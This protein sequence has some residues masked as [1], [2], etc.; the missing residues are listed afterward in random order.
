VTNPHT[1]HA[2]A[3]RIQH[4]DRADTL[5]EA[6]SQVLE[7]IVLGHP[8]HKILERLCRIAEAQATR[9]VRC[10]IALVDADG[11]RLQTVAAP[12]I[13]EVYV[14]AHDGHPISRHVGTSCAAAASGEP[15]V[16]PDIT[17]D[18]GWEPLRPIAI[19]YGLRAAWSQPIKAASGQVLGTFGTYFLERRRPTAYE[20]RL[21][22]MLARTAALAIEH[23]RADDSMRASAERER[24]L[25]ELAAATQPLSEPSEIMAVTARMLAQHLD[26]DRCTYSEVDD[27]QSGRTVG[28]YARGVPSAI[29]RWTA[30]GFGPECVESLRAGR[31]FVVNDVGDAPE[32][33]VYR[34]AKVRA[35]MIAPLLKHGRLTAAIAVHQLRP[36]AW[37]ADEVELL[38]VVCA[39]CWETLERAKVTRSLL[40]S[41]ARHRRMVEASPECVMLVAADGTLL[42]MNA[43]GSRMLEVSDAAQVVGRSIYPSIAPEHR[44]RFREWNE[45]VCAGNQGTLEFE[46]IGAHGGRRHLE[47]TAVWLPAPGGDGRVQ[48][49][50][51][52]DVSARVAADQALHESRARLDYAV[53]LSGVG[54][55]Y[56]D[57]PLDE[58]LWDAR[59]K[60]LFFLPPDDAP[61]HVDEIFQ[62][63]HP[64]DREWVNETVHRA[65]AEHSSCDM[66]HRTL[67]PRSGAIKWVRALGGCRYGEDGTPTTF[68]GVIV[69]VTSQRLD[70]ERLARLLERERE[71]T[72]LL[73]QLADASLRIHGS[74][75]LEN[76][77]QA[78]TEQASQLIGAAHAATH[79]YEPPAE[80][81]RCVKTEPRRASQLSAPLIGRHGVSLGVV[82]LSDKLSGEFDEA[83]VAILAQLAHI[84]AVAIENARLYDQLREQDRRKD[85]FLA[86]LAH[87]LRNPL[88]PI[89][90]G[91]GVLKIAGD[92]EQ[93]ARAR[94]M[95]ERQLGHM[96]RMVDDLLEISR[97]T[98]G[99]LELKKERVDARA[100]VKQAL[101][102]TLPLVQARKHEFSL[103]M[104]DQ[105]LIVHADPTRLS[106]IIVNLVNNAA[107]YTPEGGRIALH[108]ESDASRLHIRVCDSGVGIAPEMLPKVFDMFTQVGGALERSQGGLGIGLTLVR[109]LVEMHGGTVA[110]S[111]DGPGRGSTFTVSLPLSVGQTVKGNAPYVEATRRGGDA[112]RILVVDDNVDGAECL[113]L[114]LE[115]RGHQTRVAYSGADALVAAR[116]FRPDVI[117]LDIG[118]PGLDGYQVAEKLRADPDLRNTML[119]A[120]TGWGSSSDR[121]RA[122]AAGFDQH[123]VKPLDTTKLSEILAK[124]EVHAGAT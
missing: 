81:A 106:Q 51:G 47:T 5:F 10:A 65:I 68:N 27:L 57:L 66:T 82:S 98:L 91:L 52:R 96:V 31:P 13:P 16:T 119:V 6:Q 92:S 70:Q 67:D 89:R 2:A 94:D 108:A 12:T 55:F 21:V 73:G 105:P 100:V 38:S 46:I 17:T 50:M 60:E 74:G 25:S 120:L 72:R 124:H 95:M 1:H 110:A 32:L 80:S 113:S 7:L 111:S 53:R 83:D 59:S 87:E 49:G 41:E 101:E 64:D 29:G 35:V 40:E 3:G 8:L 78:V 58:M 34:A 36:R 88:A 112:Q 114:L 103:H 18:P 76:V 117:F 84:A 24:F 104:A 26:A 86:M 14:L 20:R 56:C 99:K 123:L 48:L 22:E 43:A 62:R 45:W 69:D 33:K 23:Q 116:E 63:L 77:L 15:V 30:A 121:R 93:A 71:Q 102:T 44:E 28:E 90:T 109:R 4:L 9:P 39:R 42:Q 19:K 107:K 85:E 118:L 115:L 97:I 37:T 61:V 79:L 11:Q 54:F 75:A 122:E